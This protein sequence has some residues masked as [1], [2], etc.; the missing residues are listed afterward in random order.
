L[1]CSGKISNPGVDATWHQILTSTSALAPFQEEKA[2]G[3]QTKIFERPL[4]DDAPEALLLRRLTRKR[5]LSVLGKKGLSGLRSRM[6]K[7]VLKKR[8]LGAAF[9]APRP[10]H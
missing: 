7:K 9:N 8:G 4:S 10:S 3:T 6:K 1:Q 2:A 5:R